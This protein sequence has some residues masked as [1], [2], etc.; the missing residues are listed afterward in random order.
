MKFTFEGYKAERFAA[1]LKEKQPELVT[2]AT[3]ILRE[4][5]E[6]WVN[7]VRSGFTGWYGGKNRTGSTPSGRL[8]NRGKLKSSIGGRVVGNR[9]DS[10]R[11]IF[12]VGG[13]AAFYAETQEDGANISGSWMTIPV[14]AALTGAGRLKSSAKIIKTS[15]GWGT[16]G[17]GRTFIRHKVIFSATTKG[18]GKRR[19]PLALYILRR[20][21]KIPPRLG[22]RHALH[23]ME[24]EM[25]D[26]FR[27]RF[28][29]IL[30]DTG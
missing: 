2:A 21:V 18:G 3:R 9:L 28:F 12:R 1:G 5:V 29:T 6:E 23:R 11:A 15:D 27:R 13:K 30:K 14:G 24:P 10:M 4:S 26:S 16:S 22:A 19:K 8:R 25:M 20:S 7:K 17:M